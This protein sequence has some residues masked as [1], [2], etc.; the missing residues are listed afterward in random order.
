M[1][2]VL[3]TNILVSALLWKGPPHALLQYG[4][5]GRA[6]LFTSADL[7]AELDEVL[8]RP[9]MSKRLRLARV[10]G[11]DLVHGIAAICTMV[12]PASIPLAVIDDPDDDSVLACAVATNAEIIV[13]GDDHLLQLREYEGIPVSTAVEA[14]NRFANDSKPV[15]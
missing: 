6:T 1:R 11:I 8:A 12:E 3:D 2:L 7:L 9:K 5:V 4:R 13:S 15:R 14:L 10:R